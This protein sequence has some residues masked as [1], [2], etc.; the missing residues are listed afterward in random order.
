M[1]DL[2]TGIAILFVVLIVS[3]LWL[4]SWA[5]FSLGQTDGYCAA[6]GGTPIGMS[7]VCDVNGSVVRVE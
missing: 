2:S 1:K 5:S 7:N 6:L 4:V 3:L